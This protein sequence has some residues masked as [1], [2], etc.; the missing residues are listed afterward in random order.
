VADLD[1]LADL[2]GAGDSPEERAELRGF[3]EIDDDRARDPL[4]EAR[5]GAGLSTSL[6]SRHWPGTAQRR[7]ASR[8]WRPAI[9]IGGGIAAM[10]RLGGPTCCALLRHLSEKPDALVRLAVAPLLYRCD[11]RDGELW[12]SWIRRE[13]D[14]AV[15]ALLS[16]IAGG[17][18]V[19]LTDGALDHLATQAG[20]AD[21]PAQVRA[22]AAWAVA[23]QDVA[24][25]TAIAKT[26]LGD[27]G[28]A[29][30]LSSVVRRR[31]GPL[32]VLVADIPGDPETDQTADSLGLPRPA[33]R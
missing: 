11:E 7:S 32:V 8:S 22:G 21:M 2:V 12:S 20:N 19:M 10:R 25:G 1:A 5:P 28:T 31:G 15:F 3:A 33:T 23:Q 18:C 4:D 14:L 6:T 17:G 30:A 13:R 16:A 27:C 24:R 29:F 26:L 9:R